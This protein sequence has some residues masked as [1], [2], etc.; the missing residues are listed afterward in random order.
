[1]R[2]IRRVWGA[3]VTRETVASLGD[4][5]VLLWI[6]AVVA[7]V[8]FS[9]PFLMRVI[10][11]RIRAQQTAA[12]VNRGYEQLFN[13]EEE[14]LLRDG[15]YIDPARFARE[16]EITPLLDPQLEVLESAADDNHW[17][18]K[19]RSRRAGTV[20]TALSMT[21]LTRRGGGFL[22]ECRPID[23]RDAH[24]AHE[25]HD[26]RRTTDASAPAATEAP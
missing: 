5:D 2:R 14:A 25:T 22:K 18:L 4:L 17:F 24:E 7:C 6:L 11:P 16:A 3:V 26:P 21:Y 23:V 20:C 1:M 13:A 9:T 19:L 15:N 10:P 12:E 8:A